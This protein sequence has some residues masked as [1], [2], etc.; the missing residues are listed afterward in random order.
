[1]IRLC[2]MFFYRST[3]TQCRRKKN[4][5]WMMCAPHDF[6]GKSPFFILMNQAI[7]CLAVVAAALLG[8]VAGSLLCSFSNLN[9]Q[10]L[11]QKYFY[12]IANKSHR[13]SS[14]AASHFFFY[15]HAGTGLV[16]SICGMG[17]YRQ[18]TDHR[19]YVLLKVSKY[20]PMGWQRTD[21][22]QSNST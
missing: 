13:P 4:S 9:A 15:Q 20:R 22:N 2:L 21:F 18:R 7:F 11:A 1:M 5:H 19:Y 6:C 3:L 10:S 16:R 17:E 8:P 12:R 14:H